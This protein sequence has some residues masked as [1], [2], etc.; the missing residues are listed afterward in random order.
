[1]QNNPTIPQPRNL[2]HSESEC[3]LSRK[4]SQF[5]SE[6]PSHLTSSQENLPEVVSLSST[7]RR[8][9]IRNRTPVHFSSTKIS[10]RFEPSLEIATCQ[11]FDQL[12]QGFH[13]WPSYY[14]REP[15]IAPENSKRKNVFMQKSQ[16]LIWYHL[17]RLTKRPP[18][19][20]SRQLLQFL[21]LSAN[22]L[23]P[24]GLQV[25]RGDDPRVEI[26]ISTSLNMPSSSAVEKGPLVWL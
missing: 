1:M 15:E 20:K 18:V 16:M 23:A 10:S 13:S 11:A 12:F 7:K 4:Y 3:Y 14:H 22:L 25:L 9:H 2:N 19:L 17:W 24:V 5:V 26:T 21:L 8:F 6:G